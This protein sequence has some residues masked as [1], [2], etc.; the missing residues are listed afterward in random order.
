M[1]LVPL[2]HVGSCCAHRNMTQFH[3]GGGGAVEEDCPQ[4]LL[5]LGSS[6]H[7]DWRTVRKVKCPAWPALQGGLREAIRLLKLSLPNHKMRFLV[8]FQ[9]HSNPLQVERCGCREASSHVLA[10]RSTCKNPQTNLIHASR[11]KPQLCWD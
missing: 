5:P 3:R 2:F 1:L 9:S 11:K 6:H 10:M 8:R 7:R 4:L